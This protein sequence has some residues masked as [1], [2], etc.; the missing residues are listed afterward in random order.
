MLQE[1]GVAPATPATQSRPDADVLAEDDAV[2]VAVGHE[3]RDRG[4]DVAVRGRPASGPQQRVVEAEEVEAE[5][6]APVGERPE[7]VRMV[8]CGG[9]VAEDDPISARRPPW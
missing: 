3:R 1:V 4:R 5:G 8:D 2:R 6:G 7:L 9:Q